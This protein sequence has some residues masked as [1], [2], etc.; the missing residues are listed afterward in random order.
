MWTRHVYHAEGNAI[1][2]HPLQGGRKRGKYKICPKKGPCWHAWL[3][4]S[5][6]KRIGT[7]LAPRW[8]RSQRHEIL[9]ASYIMTASA[10]RPPFRTL[11]SHETQPCLTKGVIYTCDMV[12]HRVVVFIYTCQV[13]NRNLSWPT[14]IAICNSRKYSP[15]SPQQGTFREM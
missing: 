2:T 3:L 6:V 13:L 11:D 12:L 9:T 5:V 7:F 4:D 10:W 15:K 1:C 8:Q 14:F